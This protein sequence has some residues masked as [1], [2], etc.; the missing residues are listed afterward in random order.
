MII[1]DLNHLD[2]VVAE[3]TNIIGSDGGPLLFV[4]PFADAQAF[5]KA[6]GIGTQSQSLTFTNTNAV[7]G[8]FST[9]ESQSHSS[10]RF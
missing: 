5:S 10:A 3:E 4:V 6:T 1:S 2:E 7:S 9:S 8:L